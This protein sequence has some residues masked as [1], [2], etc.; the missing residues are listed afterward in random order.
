[1]WAD[2]PPALV[3][4]TA[5]LCWIFGVAFLPGLAATLIGLLAMGIGV[6]GIP[7][8]IAAARLFRLGGPLLRGEPQAAKTAREVSRYVRWLYFV[9]LAVPAVFGLSPILI[10]EPT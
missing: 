10:S 3:H 5:V 1:M 2:G 6:V 7:G 8:L 9:V 4:V